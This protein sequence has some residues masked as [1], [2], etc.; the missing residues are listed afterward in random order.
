[1]LR[2]GR[3]PGAPGLKSYGA[4]NIRVKKPGSREHGR[5]KTKEF[6]GAGQI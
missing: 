6:G 5:K 1:M 2:G 3:E 4:G